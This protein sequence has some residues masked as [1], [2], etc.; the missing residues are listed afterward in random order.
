[1]VIRVAQWKRDG[2]ITHRSQGPTAEQK[3]RLLIHSTAA[4]AHDSALPL[5]LLLLLLLRLRP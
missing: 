5:L 1:M 3:I 2:L 4:A